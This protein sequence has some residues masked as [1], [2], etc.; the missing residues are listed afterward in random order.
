MVKMIFFCRRRSDISHERY[1]ELLLD[2]HVPLALRHHPAMRQYVVNVVD[3]SPAGWEP[4]DSVGELWFDDLR[5]YRE[6][7]YDSPEG[8]AAVHDD[9][10]RFIGGVHAYATTEHVQKPRSSAAPI[11]RRSPG[12]KMIC[13]LFRRP[14]MTHEAFVT[15]W[16]ERHVPLALSHHPGLT[17]Y[18]TNVVDERLSPDAPPLDGVAELHF[19]SAR[20]F[21]DRLFDSADGERIVREDLARFIG[22]TSAYVATEYVQ[23]LA[24]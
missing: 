15:H 12:V 16:L 11:G 21:R 8:E 2:G 17:R 18:V 4:F 10:A 1:V 19:E 5:S 23:K 24:D 20:D 6:R 22:R 3:G 14:E 13:P 7:L 9:V